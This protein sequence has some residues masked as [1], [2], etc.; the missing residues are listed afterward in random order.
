[1]R[2]YQLTKRMKMGCGGG[3]LDKRKRT[4][5]EYCFMFTI[6]SIW[7]GFNYFMSLWRREIA[8]TSLDRTSCWG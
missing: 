8:A 2:N 6:H 7:Y 3:L 5:K 1:M 4:E